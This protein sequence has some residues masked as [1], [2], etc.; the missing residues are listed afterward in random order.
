MQN[1][2]YSFTSFVDFIY[3]VLSRN[4]PYITKLWCLLQFLY[5]CYPL[6]S[7]KNEDKY[8]LQY[9]LVR[10]VLQFVILWHC[11]TFHMVHVFRCFS[12]WQTK[13]WPPVHGLHPW[14]TNINLPYNRL[15]CWNLVIRVSKLSQPGFIEGHYTGKT[16]LKL[17]S[18]SFLTL[19][20]NFQQRSPFL[21]SPSGQSTG[22]VRGLGGQCFV[23]YK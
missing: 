5:F 3:I 15:R 19:I 6:L 2:P 18:L 22:V 21:R 1:Y 20:I 12:R 10:G 13:H 4:F 8:I 23:Q 9:N 11:S 7:G 16:D 14:T 17:D